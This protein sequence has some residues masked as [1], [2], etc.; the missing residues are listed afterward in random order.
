MSDKE[1]IKQLL[2]IFLSQGLKYF[3]AQQALENYEIEFSFCFNMTM[4]LDGTD[5]CV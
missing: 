5:L 3:P 4:T 2:S 1:R